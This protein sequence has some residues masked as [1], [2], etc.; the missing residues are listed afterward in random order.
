MIILKNI[1]I[2][3]K[4]K[5]MFFSICACNCQQLM[6]PFFYVPMHYNSKILDTFLWFPSG[7]KKVL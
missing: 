6:D 1:N 2:T 5:R 3:V 7:I 4:R